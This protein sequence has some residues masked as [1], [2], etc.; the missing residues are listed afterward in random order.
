M[1]KNQLQFNA[2]FRRSLHNALQKRQ[3]PLEKTN[4]TNSKSSYNFFH[5]C[6][7][8]DTQNFASSFISLSTP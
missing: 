3:Q 2:S 5:E 7:F 4:S 1:P 8:M 6:T